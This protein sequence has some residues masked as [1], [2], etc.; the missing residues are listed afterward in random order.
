MSEVSRR[1]REGVWIAR[2]LNT[3]QTTD[4]FFVFVP[5]PATPKDNGMIRRRVGLVFLL[6]IQ[7]AV[8]QTQE[9]NNL[10][11]LAEEAFAQVNGQFDA[12]ATL[13]EIR[14]S[15]AVQE[16][17]RAMMR[18]PKAL[19][20]LSELMKDP[21]FKAQVEAFVEN[22]EVAR[23]LRQQGPAALLGENPEP[24][25][26]ASSERR[27]SEDMDYEQYAAQFTGAENAAT[28]LRSLMAAAKDSSVLAD[29]LRDLNDPEM[30]RSAQK[31]M[32]DPAFQAEMKRIMDQPEMKKILD[33]S[34]N[35]MSD[36]ANDPAKLQEVQDKVSK[37]TAGLHS[38]DL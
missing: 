31:M 30:M 1:R 5:A 37:L 4:F 33:A 20:E 36:L 2:A 27:K 11:K 21:K 15:P 18:D 38:A 8:G 17:M 29:A 32:T 23:Q 28:G 3:P 19:A 7:T 9:E 26:P 25:Q 34:K 14:S 16:K 6:V 35:L 13:E 22:P 10:Q 24:P 12:A